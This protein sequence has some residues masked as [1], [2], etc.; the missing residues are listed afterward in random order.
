[1]N[2]PFLSGV[3]GAL[4]TPIILQN[5]WPGI[6][7]YFHVRYAGGGDMALRHLP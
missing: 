4:A 3:D 2:E 6:S 1:M 5:E 7:A